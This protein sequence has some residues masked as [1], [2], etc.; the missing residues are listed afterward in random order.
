M[1]SVRFDVLESLPSPVGVSLNGKLAV[2]GVISDIS[3]SLLPGT[4]YY[5]T[6]TGVL[7]PSTYYGRTPL[8]TPTQSVSY[9]SPRLLPYVETD[10]VIILE[11][12]RIGVALSSTSLILSNF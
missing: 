3:G 8:T 9:V 4:T 12:A 11:D 2:S 7:V 10:D 1:C 6:T 5:T